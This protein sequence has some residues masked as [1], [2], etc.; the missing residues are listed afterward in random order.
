MRHLFF[1]VCVST[2]RE[3]RDVFYH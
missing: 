2:C 3:L 1:N